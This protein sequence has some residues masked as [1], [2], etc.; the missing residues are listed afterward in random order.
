MGCRLRAKQEYRLTDGIVEQTW[1][2]NTKLECPCGGRGKFEEA[3]DWWE[4][5][6]EL[7]VPLFSYRVQTAVPIEDTCILVQEKQKNDS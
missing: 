5:G 6:R 1:A 4:L 3:A 2:L 7:Q